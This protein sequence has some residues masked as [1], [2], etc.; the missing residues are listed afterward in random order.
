M[1]ALHFA[2]N[3]AD[4]KMCEWLCEKNVD[5]LVLNHDERGNTVLHFAAKNK[6]FGKTLVP[7]L[8]SKGVN[9]NLKNNNSHSAF[10]VALHTENIAAAEELLKAGA[11]MDINLE[12]GDN[13]ALHFCT[14]NNKLLSAKFVVGLNKRLIKEDFQGITILHMAAQT[15]DLQ[16]CKF[17]VENGADV[18]AKDFLGR[19]VLVYVPR[20]QKEKRNYFLSLGVRC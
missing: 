6:M 3:H 10:C 19:S 14:R 9:V 17:L 7:F 15:A 12:S 11:D 1:N 2:A 13:N 5:A 4:L 8:V 18:H 20:K 16:F